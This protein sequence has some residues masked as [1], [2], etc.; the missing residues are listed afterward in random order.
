MPDNFFNLDTLEGGIERMLAD[1]V[2]TNIFVG[3]E[4]MLSVVECDPN[5]QGSIHSHPQEQWGG[6][7]EGSGFG[8]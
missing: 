5:S 6:C 3:D 7:L 1:R 2:N 8:A 4:A